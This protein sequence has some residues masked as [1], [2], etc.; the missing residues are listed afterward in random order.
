MSQVERY[1]EQCSKI[2]PHEISPFFIPSAKPTADHLID[3]TGRS[4]IPLSGEI[5]SPLAS[6]AQ[7]KCTICGHVS[8]DIGELQLQKAGEDIF[9]KLQR[10]EDFQSQ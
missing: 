6:S 7:F 5:A 9:S 2:T 8:V 10:G 3:L 1:C 4:E